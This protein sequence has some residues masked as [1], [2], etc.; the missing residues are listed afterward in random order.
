MNV[1]QHVAKLF[2]QNLSDIA[3]IYMKSKEDV[4]TSH[5]HEPRS[6]PVSVGPFSDVVGGSA[7]PKT[8]RCSSASFRDEMNP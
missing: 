7:R 4:C 1:A 6:T 3:T 2:S 5:A 8:D